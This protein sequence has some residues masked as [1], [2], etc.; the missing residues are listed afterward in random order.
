M[1]MFLLMFWMVVIIIK[2]MNV[3]HI[4]K[5]IIKMLL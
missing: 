4:V 2:V 1:V 5:L 3:I